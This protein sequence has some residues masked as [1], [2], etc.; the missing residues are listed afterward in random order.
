MDAVDHRGELDGDHQLVPKPHAD[1][2]LPATLR[3][4]SEI[5]RVETIAGNGNTYVGDSGTLYIS[6]QFEFH[7]DR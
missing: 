5:R 4:T 7:F 3:P 6:R 2:P 1:I